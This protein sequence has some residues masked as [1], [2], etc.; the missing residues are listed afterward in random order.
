MEALPS[1]VLYL[2]GID[3]S[4][5][6]EDYRNGK[7]SR[8]TMPQEKVTFESRNNQIL[9]PGSNPQNDDIFIVSTGCHGSETFATTNCESYRLFSHNGQPIKKGT[10]DWCRRVFDEWRFG[11][12]LDLSFPA[13]DSSLMVAH[14]EGCHCSL[15][16]ALAETRL[17]SFDSQFG[18]RYKRA[19]AN[20]RALHARCYPNKQLVPSPFYRLFTTYGGS[21]DPNK[22]AFSSFTPTDELIAVPIK[23]IFRA[24]KKT[25]NSSKA[26]D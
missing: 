16:C 1:R 23:T 14:Y 20:I 24:Q 3:T 13:D 22:I 5:L 18:D 19:E 7:F 26:S 4:K 15:E 2:R 9:V 6:I 11:I 17:L 25:G 8:V 10:C 21:I 12:V